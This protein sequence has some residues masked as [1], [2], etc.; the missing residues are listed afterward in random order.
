MAAPHVAGVAALL[1]SAAPYLRG[2]V[3]EIEAILR[4]TARPITVTEK[5]GLTPGE[6][7]PNNTT[8]YGAIDAVAAV[9]EA[10]PF[11]TRF[12]PSDGAGGLSLI[13][14]NTSGAPRSGVTVVVKP[15]SSGPLTQTVGTL[16][17]GQTATVSVPLA[18]GLA[19]ELAY[20]GLASV[21][22]VAPLAP[23]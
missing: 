9:T 5:C 13:L 4:Q 16:G 7:R 17:P 3:T 6:A 10:L 12:A 1:L 14:T 21:R 2:N 18:A 15:T 8:G 22:I 11:D 19:F 20:Q 23:P